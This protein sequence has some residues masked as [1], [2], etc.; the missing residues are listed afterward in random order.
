MVNDEEEKLRILTT[1]SGKVA[2]IANSRDDNP[3]SDEEDGTETTDDSTEE[4]SL[5]TK[6]ATRRGI[7][8]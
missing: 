2:M 5:A 6:N 8:L 3:S 7:L 4:D 1:V